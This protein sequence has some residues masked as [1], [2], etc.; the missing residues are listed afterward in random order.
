MTLMVAGIVP[1]D[2]NRACQRHHHESPGNELARH[3]IDLLEPPTNQPAS[4]IARCSSGISMETLLEV[5]AEI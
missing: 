4:A 3:G 1:F 2:K 5:Y